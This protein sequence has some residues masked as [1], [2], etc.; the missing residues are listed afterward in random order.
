MFVLLES[1]SQALLVL[2]IAVIALLGQQPLVFGQPAG[3][4]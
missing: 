1:G 4:A 3:P 2:P